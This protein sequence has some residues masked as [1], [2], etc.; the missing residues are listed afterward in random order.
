MQF[1]YYIVRFKLLIC[2]SLISRSKSF[3]YYIVRF[4]L[5]PILFSSFSFS[6]FHTT[7][8]DLNFSHFFIFH[9][10]LFQ[11]PYY[12][13]RFKPSVFYFVFLIFHLFPYYI[14][15]FKLSNDDGKKRNNIRFHT[16]QY[17]LNHTYYF[18]HRKLGL[19]FPYYIVRFKLY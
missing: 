5:R 14:V 11:F 8:Y 19:Q 2:F 7:Q 9:L 13:V 10:V 18:S 4:K 6:G 15:R 17:D 1:P 12:I 3:P 16:T